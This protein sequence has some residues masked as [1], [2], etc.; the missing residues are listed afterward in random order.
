MAV[1][2]FDAYLVPRVSVTSSTG[3]MLD[4]VSER[5]FDSARWWNEIALPPGYAEV[6][7]TLLPRGQHWSRD[8]E[9]WGREDADCISVTRCGDAVDELRVR[10]DVRNINYLFIDRIADV[11]RRWDCVFLT[12]DLEVVPAASNALQKQLRDSSA[13]RYLLDPTSFLT[14]DGELP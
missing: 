10:I 7:S 6:L 8:V 14:Q 13:Y 5:A 12:E 2:Q 4:R 3:Q 1:W 9:F 11:A